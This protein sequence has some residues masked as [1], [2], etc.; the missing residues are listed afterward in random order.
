MLALTI[1]LASLKTKIDNLDVDKLKSF[2]ANLS[3]LSNAVH[4]DVKKT[5]YDK[6]VTKTNAAD[7]QVLVDYSLKQYDSDKQGLAKMAEDVDK[8]I[9][10]NSGLDKKTDYNKKNTEIANKI[11]SVTGLVTAAVLNTKGTKIAN[12]IPDIFWLPKLL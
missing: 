2:S 7:Y 6:L 11:P 9:P 5:V 4:S 1:D 8:K 3:K 10:T 12:K